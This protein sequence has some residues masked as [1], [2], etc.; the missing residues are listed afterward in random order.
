MGWLKSLFKKPKDS[1]DRAEAA[2]DVDSDDDDDDDD[3]EEQTRPAA[4]AGAAII[5]KWDAKLAEIQERWAAMLAEAT[6]GSAPLVEATESDLAPLTRPWTA[7]QNQ[8]HNFTE[9]VSDLWDEISDELSELGDE[10]PDEEMDKQ[11]EKRDLVSCDIEIAYNR[12]YHK[13]MGAAA[14]KMREWA[15]R[16]D[17]KE[18][19]C[20]RCGAEL[21]KVTPV[22]Q[23]LNVECDYCQAMNTV[24]PADAVRMF[25][26]MGTLYLGERAAH[27]AWATMTK[28]EVLIHQYR[29]DKDIPL[30][31]LK[32]Y[33]S[34]AREFYTTRA[35]VQGDYVPEET[36]YVENIVA[37]RMQDVQK[38]L[39][40][41]WHWRE[42]LKASESA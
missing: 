6:E 35:T 9:E 4:G 21:A 7:V 2:P 38:T 25:A 1:A 15:L 3:D 36:K 39:R 16:A 33:E 29:D 27:D 30:S 41:Y 28:T 22:S 18:Q 5:A 42:H 14:D 32:T 26:A 40:Q 37:S 11:G 17:A 12:E 10:L 23:A 19:K 20:N 13:V 34:S 31:L 8:M 24:K